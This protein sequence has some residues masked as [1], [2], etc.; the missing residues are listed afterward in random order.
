MEEY[1]KSYLQ[2]GIKVREKVIAENIP[3]IIHIAQTIHNAFRKNRKLLICGNGGSAADAQHVAAELVNRYRK[4]RAPLPAVALTT[5]TSIITAVSNDYSF[6][7]IFS[8]QIEALAKNG[9]CLL[10]ISTSGTSPNIINAL[11]SARECGCTTISLT[12][13]NGGDMPPLSDI[14][15]IVPSGETPVIQEIHL[16]VEHLI[17]D[18][19]EQMVLEHHEYQN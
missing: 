9:D 19:I 17:C 4:E 12:G 16:A 11:K 10:A 18:L 8:K 6:D 5:D 14:C 3:D 13:K 1:V 15:L 7:L 2:E